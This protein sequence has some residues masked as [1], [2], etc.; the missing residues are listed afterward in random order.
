MRAYSRLLKKCSVWLW[1]WLARRGD[2]RMRS[3]LGRRRAVWRGRETARSCWRRHELRQ[4][5][6]IVSGGCEG[7]GPSDAVAATEAGLVL[8]GNHLDPAERF[9]NALADTLA[10]G[11][12]AVPRR[13]QLPGWREAG[14]RAEPA[15]PDQRS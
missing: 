3:G 7:E 2:R 15:P 9:L 4:S 6:Q 8:A 13:S 12:A 10:D 5:H 1:G 14:D 11:I